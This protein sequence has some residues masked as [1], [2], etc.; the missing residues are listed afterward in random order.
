MGSFHETSERYGPIPS[1][2]S[3]R[4]PG[5]K[6]VPLAPD[7]PTPPPSRSNSPIDKISPAPLKEGNNTQ[8][9]QKD[10]YEDMSNV[11]EVKFLAKDTLYRIFFT[12]DYPFQYLEKH[13]GI[14]PTDFTKNK[15]L[16]KFSHDFDPYNTPMR[17]MIREAVCEE[18]QRRKAAG[19]DI[20][21]IENLGGGGMPSRVR[22]PE[23]RGELITTAL[24]QL[25]SICYFHP[26]RLSQD[27]KNQLQQEMWAIGAALQAARQIRLF[28]YVSGPTVDDYLAEAAIWLNRAQ[29]TLGV[30]PR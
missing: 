12:E 10:S 28:G 25:F 11:T 27:Q 4:H 22:T 9:K 26:S 17:N 14:P 29:A 18:N 3:Q 30:E 6:V 8:G 24:I 15:L 21:N 20:I 5:F 1:A 13:Y 23:E 19:K 16:D 7:L 2:A